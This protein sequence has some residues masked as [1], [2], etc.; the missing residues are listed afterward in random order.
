MASLNRLLDID[1]AILVLDFAADGKLVEYKA[2][3]DT[4]ADAAAVAQFCATVTML[5]NTLASSFAAQ[6]GM[7][8]LPQNGWV[9]C[10]GDW[11]LVA[12]NGTRAVIVDANKVDI[13]RTID[14]LFASR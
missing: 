5:F 7:K 1:G 14:T 11:T 3:Q 9:L 10:S 8:W 12:D 13:N 2:K 6:T 4:S